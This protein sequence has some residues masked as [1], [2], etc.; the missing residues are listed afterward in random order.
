M[1]NEGKKIKAT[2]MEKLT[3]HLSLIHN[4]LITI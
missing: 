3:N 4:Q 1:M 2:V